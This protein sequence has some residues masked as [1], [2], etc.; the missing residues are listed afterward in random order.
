MPMNGGGVVENLMR[1]G[2]THG[3]GSRDGEKDNLLS[4]PFRGAELGRWEA[5]AHSYGKRRS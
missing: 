3:E 5:A 1:L 2:K 4:F